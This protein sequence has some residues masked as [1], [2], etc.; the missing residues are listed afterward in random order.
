MSAYYD[1][2]DGK[3]KIRSFALDDAAGA[4]RGRPIRDDASVIQR[5][6]VTDEWVRKVMDFA[7]QHNLTRKVDVSPPR[8]RPP[9]SPRFS[10]AW[11]VGTN[12]TTDKSSVLIS[13]PQTP[14]RNPSRLSTRAVSECRA[15]PIY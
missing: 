7:Q 15:V 14:V 1:I 2:K 10:H 6:D 9:P 11:V 8:R 3:K 13:D 12:K 5:N 4:I